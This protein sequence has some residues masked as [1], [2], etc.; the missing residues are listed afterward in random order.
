MTEIYWYETSC[1]DPRF[2][3]KE[4]EFAT[5]KLAYDKLIISQTITASPELILLGTV[6]GN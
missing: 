1:K 5:E 4:E 6:G 2:Y 3:L